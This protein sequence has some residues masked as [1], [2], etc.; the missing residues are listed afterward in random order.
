MHLVESPQTS[1]AP[2][3]TSRQRP[4]RPSSKRTAGRPV[5]HPPSPETRR[6]LV[7]LST[8]DEPA[9]EQARAAYATGNES[10]FAGDFDAAIESY[11][12]AIGFA[13]SYAAGHRGLGLAYAE[14]GDTAAALKAFR[15]Y[16]SLAP[17]AKDV[18]LIKRRI[19][20]LQANH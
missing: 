17:H 11:R 15:T 5:R 8:D 6:E 20:G 7:A 4:T 1:R 12:Q 18:A 19:A 10:L 16:L 2:A 13:P 3:P 9:V 14:Q